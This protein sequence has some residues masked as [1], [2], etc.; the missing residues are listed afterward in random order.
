[1]IKRSKL[2][3]NLSIGSHRPSTTPTKYRHFNIEASL[4]KQNSRSSSPAQNIQ[5][6]QPQSDQTIQP[7]QT[8]Q[9]TQTIQ[10]TQTVQPTQTIQPTQTVQPTQT[11]NL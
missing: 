2:T 7:T 8:V 5:T 6:I 1:M 11:A 9:P 3:R 4:N 10:S